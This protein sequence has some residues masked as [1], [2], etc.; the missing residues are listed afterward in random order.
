VTGPSVIIT[1][2]H[3]GV[4]RPG[5]IWRILTS[6]Y[7]PAMGSA[8]HGSSVLYPL[9]QPIGICVINAVVLNRSASSF[10]KRV[11]AP[12][13]SKEP[14]GPEQFNFR[15]TCARLGLSFLLRYFS[16][17]WQIFG[18]RKVQ[19]K[20]VLLRGG[21]TSACSPENYQERSE[22]FATKISKQKS[23]TAFL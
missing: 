5:T 14:F 6:W 18:Q 22:K 8:G 20:I 16:R 3:T 10:R 2:L 1:P 11:R 17:K 9:K 15:I 19:R 7:H 4:I 12:W 23:V 13:F 21:P